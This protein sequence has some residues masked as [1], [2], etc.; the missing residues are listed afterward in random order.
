MTDGQERNVDRFLS[1]LEKDKTGLFAIDSIPGEDS[2]VRIYFFFGAEEVLF[3]F[4]LD[5]PRTA[6]T[7]VRPTDQTGIFYGRSLP[8]V[9]LDFTNGEDGRIHLENLF[10]QLHRSERAQHLG[11][12]IESTRGSAIRDRKGAKVDQVTPRRQTECRDSQD[13]TPFKRPIG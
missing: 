10:L 2:M 8:L 6:I 3:D 1:D 5:V 13:I 11:K 7:N 12:Y 9:H 4:F